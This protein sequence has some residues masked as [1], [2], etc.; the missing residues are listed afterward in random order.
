[1]YEFNGGVEAPDGAR[2]TCAVYE[3]NAIEDS[4]HENGFL[5]STKAILTC[6]ILHTGRPSHL[7]EDRL[8]A[9][10]HDDSHQSTGEMASMMDCDKLILVPHLHSL[11][12]VQK[13]GW[14]TTL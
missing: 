7:D 1:M 14:H 12:K 13:N 5:V 9:L 6:M 3:E 4:Q 11:G 2:T 8:N 10:I